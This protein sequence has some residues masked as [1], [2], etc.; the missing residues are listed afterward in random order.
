MADN[1]TI[2]QNA[3]STPPAGTVIATDDVSGV[4]YQVMKVDLG[5]DGSSS[6]LTAG[7]KTSANSLPVVLS[8]DAP[9]VLDSQTGAFGELSVSVL[10]PRAVLSFSY[11]INAD[12]VNTDETGS[13]AVTSEDRMAKLST[14]AATSSTASLS[15]RTV[16]D[17]QP[18]VGALGRGTAIFTAGVAGSEQWI[19]V[20]DDLDGF[21]FGYNGADFCINRR[22]DG[23]DNVT[24]QANWNEDNADGTGTLPVVDFTK[25]NVFEIKYQWLGFGAIKFS[26]ANP[27]TGKFV[28]VHT[29]QY[30]NAN[31]SPS[32][33]NPSFPLYA[34]V[35]NTT[36]NTDV[37]LKTA[38]MGGYLEGEHK[39][40]GPL[41][42]ID[43]NKAGV[44]TTYTNIL[45]IRNK[46]TYQSVRN[47][48]HLKILEIS[49]DADGTKAVT[50]KMIRDAT[51][52]GTPS[53]TDIDTNTSAVDYD[54]AGTTV[55]GGVALKTFR[56]SKLESKDLEMEPLD[57]E[58]VRGET[59]TIAAAT[60]SGTSDIGAAITWRES[61]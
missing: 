56:L 18:G 55:T 17:Y 34:Y 19:G 46:T 32:V 43:N 11:N 24:T 57:I 20:G 8:S 48:I 2:T 27:T 51:L 14:G 4:Q 44:G 38:S 5:G 30:A 28:L 9:V 31:T 35:G 37:V 47:R 42:S 53:Y 26:I 60:D 52:G 12:L 50:I 3:N 61:V 6:P 40:T 10:H 15:S 22:K 33:D 16:V 39:A 23:V 54:T 25:G 36:N 41:K 45:T 59:L 21:F 58:L 7:Q 13:G 1:V 29:I 49:A